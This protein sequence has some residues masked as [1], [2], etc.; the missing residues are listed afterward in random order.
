MNLLL[1][2]SVEEVS[3]YVGS[4]FG[5]GVPSAMRSVRVWKMTLKT[6]VFNNTS[7]EYQRQSVL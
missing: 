6:A 4:F 5:L 1:L 7:T 3:F 2:P